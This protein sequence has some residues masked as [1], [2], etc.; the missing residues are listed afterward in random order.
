MNLIDFTTYDTES[1]RLLQQMRCSEIDGVD[2][3]CADG[4]SWVFGHHDLTTQYVGGTPE[5]ETEPRIGL[6]GDGLAGDPSIDD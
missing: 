5:G 1:R 4:V 3:Q 6:I 2:L